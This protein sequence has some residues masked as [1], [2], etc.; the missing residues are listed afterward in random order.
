MKTVALSC[1]F[2]LLSASAWAANAPPKPRPVCE[3]LAK[4]KTEFPEGATFTKL[5]P[6]QYNFARGVYVISPDTQPGLPPGKSA[7][8]VMPKGSKNGALI[9]MDNDKACNPMLA[10]EM[11]I[12]MIMEIVTGPTDEEG[13]EL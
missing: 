1:A 8:L 3:T 9:W 4:V 6:G 12:K 2:A 13:N 11:L 10:P 7:L 5:T